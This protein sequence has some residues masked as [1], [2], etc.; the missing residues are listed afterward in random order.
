MLRLCLRVGGYAGIR[1]RWADGASGLGIR[2]TSR[3][4]SSWIDASFYSDGI[5]CRGVIDV[6]TG[7]WIKIRAVNNIKGSE[8]L[9]LAFG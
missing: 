8:S 6:H 1:G 2:G 3:G 9:G 4:L 5:V 7:G